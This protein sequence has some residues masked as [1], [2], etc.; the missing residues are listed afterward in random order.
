MLFVVIITVVTLLYS[1][2]YYILIQVLSPRN[3][4][5]NVVVY[6]QLRQ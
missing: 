1:N 3:N 5:I 4:K 2:C 6:K